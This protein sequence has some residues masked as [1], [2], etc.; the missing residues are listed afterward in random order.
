M[1]KSMAQCYQLPFGEIRIFI[2]MQLLADKDIV[3]VNWTADWH[4]AIL[5]LAMNQ[6]PIENIE[7]VLDSIASLISS[8]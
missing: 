4:T 1:G 5:S 2:R 3:H 7:K 6:L 8:S